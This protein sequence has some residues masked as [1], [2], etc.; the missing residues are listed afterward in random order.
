MKRWHLVL[1]AIIVLASAAVIAQGRGQQQ[2]GGGQGRGGGGGGGGR[3]VVTTAEVTVIDG[4]GKPVRD[5]LAGGK[6]AGPAPVRNLSGMWEPA[7]GPGA[8][9]QANGPFSMPSDGVTLDWWAPPSGA[10]VTPDGVATRMNREP[11]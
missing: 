8:G 1:A 5:P 7:N 6:T 2:G 11:T 10:S 3:G 4:W 9:I